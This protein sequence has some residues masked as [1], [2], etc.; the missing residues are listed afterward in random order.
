MHEMEINI[1]HYHLFLGGVTTVIYNTLIALRDQHPALSVTIL[2][3]SHI[4]VRR[5]LQR[6]SDSGFA[7]EAASPPSP[8]TVRVVISKELFYHN[9]TPVAHARRQKRILTVLN[10][11]RNTADTVWWVH[12]YH[13]GKNCA[14]TAAV[15]QHMQSNPLRI[16]LLHIHDFPEQG[17]AENYANIQRRITTGRYPQH[18][19]THYIVINPT[20][21]RVLHAAGIDREHAHYIPNPTVMGTHRELS[22]RYA[23]SP[24]RAQMVRGLLSNSAIRAHGA[25]YQIAPQ[26]KILIYPV[27]T[28]KRKNILEAMLITAG[29]NRFHTGAKGRSVSMP[30]ASLVITLPANS[31]QHRRYSNRVRALFVKRAVPGLWGIGK[32]IETV[33]ITYS[34]LISVS[35]AIISS[36]VQE[37][38]GF[39]MFEALLARKLFIS[40]TIPTLGLSAPYFGT[41]QLQEYREI[42]CRWEMPPLA[43]R[44]IRL[45]RYYMS[46]KSRIAPLYPTTAIRAL[47]ERI[48]EMFQKPYIDFSY[49]TCALQQRLLLSEGAVARIVECNGSL[50]EGVHN[51][52]GLP[53]P[54]PDY[55]KLT[56]AYGGG[57]FAA[58]IAATLMASKYQP[59]TPSPSSTPLTAPLGTPLTAPLGTHSTV[60]ATVAAAHCKIDYIRAILNA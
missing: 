1:I 52:M 4:N 54:P 41:A 23:I 55:T 22:T 53:F 14:L 51:T 5:F 3:G 37:G 9:D 48:E 33:G 38:F 28:I 44:K 8:Y 10:G 18:S 56:N 49:L 32:E 39:T 57:A 46:E 15:L 30:Y 42:A 17:R 16:F 11:C 19:N 59:S 20:D 34:E 13:L 35:D 25:G 58:K 27:R 26:S 40:R 31:K 7:T 43:R 21:Y 6:V 12:N 36:S 29:L 24:S 47:T 60:G 50:F 45:Y 2:C